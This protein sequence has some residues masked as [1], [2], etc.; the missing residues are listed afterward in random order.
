MTKQEKIQKLI[1]MQKKFIEQEHAGGVSAAEYFTPQEGTPLDA[2][3]EEY[4]KTAMEIVDIA[5]E[6]VGSHQ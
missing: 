5:H 2:Y 1:A 6:E 3:R 4:I